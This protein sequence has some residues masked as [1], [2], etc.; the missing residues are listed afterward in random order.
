MRADSVRDACLRIYQVQRQGPACSA[1]RKWLDTQ[2]I[3]SIWPI[4]NLSNGNTRKGTIPR[5]RRSQITDKTVVE[6]ELLVV[7]LAT[8]I[9][10]SK[11]GN[12]L[13]KTD[14]RRVQLQFQ[15]LSCATARALNTGIRQ[16]DLSETGAAI[17]CLMATRM[18][19]HT[20]F[21][22]FFQ[23]DAMA[24]PS[25]KIGSRAFSPDGVQVSH[26]KTLRHTSR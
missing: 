8:E 3:P 22:I 15:E 12:C 6:G 23:S 25:C 1:L 20:G 18:F 10:R 24:F 26:S 19:Q 16:G 5:K 11:G 4:K 21:T 17:V 13:W 2:A 14:N 9:P 7:V